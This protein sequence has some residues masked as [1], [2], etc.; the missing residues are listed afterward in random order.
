MRPASLLSASP[1]LSYQILQFA[2]HANRRHNP[3]GIPDF[4]GCQ[5]FDDVHV[6]LNFLNFMCFFVFSF[7]HVFLF[8]RTSSVPSFFVEYHAF[9][10]SSGTTE[11]PKCPIFSSIKVFPV[12]PDLLG[13]LEFF[14]CPVFLG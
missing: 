12:F 8:S 11:S 13:T 2:H 5:F 3:L 6:F 14:G 4:L 9:R 7:F 10:D 1:G